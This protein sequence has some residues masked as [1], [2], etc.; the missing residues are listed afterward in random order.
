MR[1]L[2]CT[3]AGSMGVIASSGSIASSASPG[4]R[5]SLG[6]MGPLL[7]PAGAGTKEDF[8]LVTATAASLSHSPESRG[9]DHVPAGADT[10][11]H[12]ARREAPV[13][14]EPGGLPARRK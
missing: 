4:L 3:P 2:L 6:S 11:R 7:R 13:H 10:R 1:D 14:F 5:W 12:R 8:L 9:S